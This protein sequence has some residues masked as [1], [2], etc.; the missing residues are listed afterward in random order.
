MKLTFLKQTRTIRHNFCKLYNIDTDDNTQ[1]FRYKSS[2][3]MDLV[4]KCTRTP[5]NIYTNGSI[6]ISFLYDMG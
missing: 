3:E 6:N 1:D 2:F 4:V 5:I